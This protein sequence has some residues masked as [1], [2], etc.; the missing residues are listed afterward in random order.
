MHE[1]INL[2]I[3]TD[4]AREI[5][6]GFIKSEITRVGYSRAVLA[7]SGGID[8]VLSTYLAADGIRTRK[9]ARDSLAL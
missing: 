1:K 5:L 8:S 9:C 3:N 2:A 6:T 4:L 7:L